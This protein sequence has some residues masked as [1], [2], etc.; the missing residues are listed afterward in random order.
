[1]LIEGDG[2]TGEWQVVDVLALDIEAAADEAEQS[3]IAAL[4]QEYGGAVTG[5]SVA[6]GVVG[7]AIPC[8]SGA[9]LADLIGREMRGE[10]TQAQH[11]AK[12]TL[13]ALYLMLQGAGVHDSDIA[14]IWE[15]IQ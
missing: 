2:E 11:N 9:V 1:L 10:L 4:A 8:Q 5:L 13:A 14:A 7:H 15:A 12:A 6:L 3:R